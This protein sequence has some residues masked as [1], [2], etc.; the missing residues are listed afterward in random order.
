MQLSVRQ[1]INYHQLGSQI[2][3]SEFLNN[4][5]KNQIKKTIYEK[6]D[7]NCPSVILQLI[8]QFA[9][10][11]VELQDN[12]FKNQIFFKAY[13]NLY[14]YKT[15]NY[16]K[17]R[18]LHTIT[19]SFIIFNNSLLYSMCNKNNILFSISITY[20][21]YLF[22]IDFIPLIKQINTIQSSSI[23]AISQWNTKKVTNNQKTNILYYNRF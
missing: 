22:A 9:H 3:V 4:E 21:I 5:Y 8:V 6:Y 1:L 2:E 23:T 15:S 13:E 17:L 14:G 11:N 20:G 18:L 19:N 12:I 10:N 7:I 16:I